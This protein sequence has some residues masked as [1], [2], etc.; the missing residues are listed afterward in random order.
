MSTDIIDLVNALFDQ[1]A[2]ESKKEL[3]ELMWK[4]LQD[5]VRKMEDAR[6]RE[7]EDMEFG[8]LSLENDLQEKF[9]CYYH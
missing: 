5:E 8:R 2:E 9:S 1:A 6:I 7:Y 3:H 4:K